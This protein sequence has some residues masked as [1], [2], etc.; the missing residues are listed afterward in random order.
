MI[1]YFITDC[2]G[3]LTDGKY[4]YSK[5]GKELVA[6]HANDSVAFNELKNL[7]IEVIII[8][9]G[10][11]QE[12]NSTRARDLGVKFVYAPFGEKLDTV[13]SLGI[14]VSDVA[15]VGDCSDDVDLLDKS[16]IS[17]TPYSALPQIKA[18]AD[19]VTSRCGGEGCILEILFILQNLRLV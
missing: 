9:S 4:Y 6:F 12:I 7:G 16:R 8:S 14:D 3:V 18:K 10:N 11:Y 2:D 15:Y 19:I 17:F 1:K 5:Y 13:L